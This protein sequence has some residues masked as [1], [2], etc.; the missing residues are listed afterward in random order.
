MKVIVDLEITSS[1]ILFFH[2]LL[3]L[4]EKIQLIIL[5]MGQYKIPYQSYKN[6]KV[7]NRLIPMRQ[8]LIK[9]DNK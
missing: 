7:V 8:S 6:R 4:K 9:K 1:K 2:S 5:S 3:H